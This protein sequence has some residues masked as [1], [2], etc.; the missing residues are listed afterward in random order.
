MIKV[1]RVKI[2][3]MRKKIRMITMENIKV[4]EITM[5]KVTKT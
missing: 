2:M 5:T 1:N 4:M 3:K